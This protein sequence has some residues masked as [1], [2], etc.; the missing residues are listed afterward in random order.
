MPRRAAPVCLSGRKD[1]AGS[2]P[3]A[4]THD[5]K[6]MVRV[7]N[8]YQSAPAAYRLTLVGAAVM[9]AGGRQALFDSIPSLDRSPS[10]DR[11]AASKEVGR[12]GHG[13]Q[14]DLPYPVQCEAVQIR[15]RGCSEYE[16][17][18]LNLARRLMRRTRI[19]ESSAITAIVKAESEMAQG[20]EGKPGL[21]G[22]H[23]EW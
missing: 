14:G 21:I 17:R 23:R 11:P 5:R 18:N 6:V 10:N 19:D 9:S 20:H 13:R 1:T 12:H 16:R 4:N 2:P 8:A 3:T 22:T 15:V 7:A